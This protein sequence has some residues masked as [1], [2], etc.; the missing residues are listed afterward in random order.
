[1]VLVDKLGYMLIITLS[2]Y[3]KVLYNLSLSESGQ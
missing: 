1:M 3:C 2:K